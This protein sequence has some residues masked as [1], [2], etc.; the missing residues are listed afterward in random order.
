MVCPVC[1]RQEVRDADA[2]TVCGSQLGFLRQHPRRVARCI[3]VSI[4]LGVGFFL[5]LAWHVFGPMLR[6][7]PP[8]E[9]PAPWFWWAFGLG[10]FFLSLGLAASQ[11]LREVFGRLLARERHGK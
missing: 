4:A 3:A 9:R 8:V 2:C 1:Q 5:A 10:T 6:G 11:Q 7:G